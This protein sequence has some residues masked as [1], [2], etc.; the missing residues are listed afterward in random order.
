MFKRKI[1]ILFGPILISSLFSCNSDAQNESNQATF[2]IQKSQEVHASDILRNANV[3]FQFNHHEYHR[4]FEDGQEV[5]LRRTLNS[6]ENI[7]DEWRGDQLRRW[8]NGEEVFL[9]DSMQN[10]YMNSINSVFYF[11]TLPMKLSDDAVIS[12]YIGEEVILGTNY[13]K[14]EITFTAEGGGDDYED[15]YVYWFNAQDY[16][17][18]FF[19][20]QYFTNGGGMRFRSAMNRRKIADVLVQDYANFSPIDQSSVYDLAKAYEDGQLKLVSDI[21][22]LNVQLSV[23]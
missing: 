13:H 10:V 20:Y 6:E 1:R 23:N 22:K 12:K 15:I 11:F 14:I 4:N 16:T 5:R 7:L 19:A 21:N 17:L 8:I 3:S 9:S 18:D 2:I